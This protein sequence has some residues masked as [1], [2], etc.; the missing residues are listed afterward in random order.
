MAPA[1]FVNPRFKDGPQRSRCNRTPFISGEAPYKEVQRAFARYGISTRNKTLYE[2]LRE[3]HQCL[4]MHYRECECHSKKTSEELAPRNQCTELLALI[5]HTKKLVRWVY[6]D[7]PEAMPY[8]LTLELYR[9]PTGN[10]A[11]PKTSQ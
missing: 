9:T 3:L 1:P 2:V 8:K 6:K 7:S 11:S 10:K 5:R 4:K